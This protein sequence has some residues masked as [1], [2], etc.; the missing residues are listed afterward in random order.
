MDNI[1]LE[2]KELNNYKIRLLKLK[3]ELKYYKLMEGVTEGAM[4]VG[5][6][7]TAYS[8]FTKEDSQI[9]FA[10]LT[11]V[12]LYTKL[13]VSK[14]RQETEEELNDKELLIEKKSKKIKILE[15]K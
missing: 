14:E 1:M 9:P 10:I 11:L 2:K 7:T 13:L 8:Y 6:F 12:A 3:E 15:K 5:L 4:T